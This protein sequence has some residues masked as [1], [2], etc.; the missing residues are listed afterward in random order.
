MNFIIIYYDKIT[1]TDNAKFENF[2]FMEITSIDLCC[3]KTQRTV[4][5]GSSP[6]N[7]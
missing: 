7:L 5:I 4:G 3:F 1:K 6:Y 2:F